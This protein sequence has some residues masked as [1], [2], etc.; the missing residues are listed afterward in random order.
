MTSPAQPQRSPPDLQPIG[1]RYEQSQAPPVLLERLKPAV[2]LST[3]NGARLVS[4][5]S[6]LRELR[7]GFTHFNQA[8]DLCRGASGIAVDTLDAISRVNPQQKHAADSPEFLHDI[9]FL[10][11]SCLRC[12]PLMGHSLAKG[13]KQRWDLPR[14]LPFRE[15]RSRICVCNLSYF[16][17][18]RLLLVGVI[19][20][21]A[22]LSS[23]VEQL[24]GW[25]L[26]PPTE[27]G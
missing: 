25:F 16:F 10:A 5:D 21:L 13:G 17:D 15:V 3:S 23:S 18:C 1:E 24:L 26:P 2:L 19:C 22:W 9:A 20:A 27:S 8:M 12:G 7:L 14:L 4:M 11:L 6:H